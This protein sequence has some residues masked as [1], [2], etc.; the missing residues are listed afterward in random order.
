MTGSWAGPFSLTK[1]RRSGTSSTW[2]FD[3]GTAAV[4]A[5]VVDGAAVPAPDVLGVGDF[6]VVVRATGV[7]ESL[8]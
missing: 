2:N 1:G 8:W 5:V 7:P 6:A 4:E 3:A